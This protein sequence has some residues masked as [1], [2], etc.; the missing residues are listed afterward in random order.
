MA[1]QERKRDEETTDK[2]TRN[3]DSVDAA[4]YD[5]PS[6]GEAQFIV[7]EGGW[8]EE[9]DLQDP[10]RAEENDDG[11]D[12]DDGSVYSE[13]SLIAVS[14]HK[15]EAKI[16]ETVGEI[17]K[18]MGQIG[19]KVVEIET[20]LGEKVGELEAKIER[21]VEV[22]KANI[23]KIAHWAWKSLPFDNLPHW[24]QD[25]AFLTDAHRPPMHSFTGCFKSMF[26]MHTETWN[27]WTHFL[28]F[29]FFVMLCLGIYVYG[30]YITF[31][32]EDIEVY[33]LPKTEQAML[34][35]FFLGAM[36]CLSCSTLFHLFSNHSQDVYRI[37]SCLDY[38]GIAILITGSSI[39]AYYYGF[40]CSLVPQF[41]HIGIL[42]VLCVACVILSLW[43]KFGTPKY[44]PLR[45]ATFVLF[46]LYGCIPVSHVAL[47]EGF[48]QQHV[49]QAVTGLV[50]MGGVYILGAVIYVLRI[51]ERFFPGKFNTWASS[52]QLF[53]ICVVC[54]ALI[55]Y[56]TLL[57]MIKY[58]M[59]TQTCG[60]ES[61]SLPTL[62]V[63]IV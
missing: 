57:S 61:I 51:P 16:G 63:P 33:K 27:I 53:H 11:A 44:R 3:L 25:N 21:K 58:R 4:V 2:R 60:M 50:V 56:D 54:A 38:T 7:E 13:D 37:F 34:L 14:L 8:D 30:D 59:S 43:K 10:E 31:L 17:G 23:E 39:P 49:V 40:Y 47:R 6:I 28:G 29:V 18:K 26:R 1:A 48:N 52:H 19:E 20:R 32:F 9:E 5:D 41:T 35:C 62:E 36:V 55:H 42:S 15:I 24:L 22:T 46:G 45:F 12:S